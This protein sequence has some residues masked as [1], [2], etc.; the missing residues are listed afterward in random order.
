VKNK[1]RLILVNFDVVIQT[2]RTPV[3]IAMLMKAA[4]PIASLIENGIE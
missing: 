3:I 4:N 2:I 1:T